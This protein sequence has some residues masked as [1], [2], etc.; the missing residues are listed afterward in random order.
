MTIFWKIP[1]L[2][3]SSLT[4]SKHL[5]EMRTNRM[6]CQLIP[7]KQMYEMK[8]KLQQCSTTV[9]FIPV[10]PDVVILLVSNHTSPKPIK[11]ISQ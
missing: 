7:R 4:F 6:Q 9:V 1:F 3:L 5:L 8:V 10:I 11:K 2:H